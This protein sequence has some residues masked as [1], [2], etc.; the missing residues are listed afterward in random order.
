MENI[1][2]YGMALLAIIIAFLVVKR[3]T[4]CMIQSIVTI[5]LI[6]VLGAIYYFFLR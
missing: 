3:V 5:V 1:Q 2:Y 6:V 4:S